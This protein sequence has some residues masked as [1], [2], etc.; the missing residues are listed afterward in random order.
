MKSNEAL[1]DDLITK[2]FS[3]QLKYWT[4]QLQWIYQV[5]SMWLRILFPLPTQYSFSIIYWLQEDLITSKNVL[6][7]DSCHRIESITDVF[8]ILVLFIRCRNM[9]VT[10]LLPTTCFNVRHI[11]KK[12]NN[13]YVALNIFSIPCYYYYRKTNSNTLSC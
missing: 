4:F 12:I 13:K 5:R 3:S 2:Y 8:K 7:R 1:C 10:N 6:V 9:L 11:R